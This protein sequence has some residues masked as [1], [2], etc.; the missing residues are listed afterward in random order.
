MCIYR[1]RSGPLRLE[2]YNETLVSRVLELL[3]PEPTD[4]SAATPLVTVAAKEF[5]ASAEEKEKW[6]GTRYQVRFSQRVRHV[7]PSTPVMPS[8]SI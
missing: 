3:R 4:Y 8:R 1:M 5:G 7:P 6:Y 2:R